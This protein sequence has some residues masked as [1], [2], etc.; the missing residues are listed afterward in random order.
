MGRV[1]GKSLLVFTS[2]GPKTLREWLQVCTTNAVES[3][4]RVSHMGG[5]RSFLQ[6]AIDQFLMDDQTAQRVCNLDMLPLYDDSLVQHRSNM[7]IESVFASPS[8]FNLITH[9]VIPQ[10]ADA[11]KGFFPPPSGQQALFTTRRA[12][13]RIVRL[14]PARTL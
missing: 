12:C 4:N 14:T 8:E 5:K 3:L 6:H 9:S 13:S 11:F 10:R 7:G 2:G 1:V